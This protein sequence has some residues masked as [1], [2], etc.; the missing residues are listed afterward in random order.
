MSTPSPSSAQGAAGAAGAA[1]ATGAEPVK[2]DWAQPVL[3][4]AVT[5][6]VG[7][8]GSFAVVLTGLRAVGADSAQA[9]SG[10][11]VL[12]LTM[13]GLTV[14]L[15]LRYR[16][17][18]SIV[19]STPGAAVLASAGLVAGGYGTAI[20]AFLV[21]GLLIVVTGAIPRV[22]GLIKAIPAQL[23]AALLAGVLFPL[24]SEPVRAVAQLP[25]QAGTIV[26]CWAVAARFFPRWAVPVA[27]AAAAVVIAADPSAQNG[28]TP[29]SHIGSLIPGLTF[30]AP[31]FSLGALVGLALPLFIVTM[32]SQNVP[33]IAVLDAYGYEPPVRRIMVLTGGVTMLAAPFGAVALNLSALTAAMAAGPVAHRD[34]GRRWIAAVASACGYVVLGLGAGL[35]VALTAVAS[36]LLVETVAGLAL[37]N[38]LT[39]AL[40]T[41][42]REERFR[43]P[44]VVTFLVA[45]SGLSFAGV[46]SPFWG[47][48]AGLAFLGLRYRRQ[49][50]PVVAGAVVGV[51]GGA[52]VSGTA[53][54]GADANAQIVAPASGPPPVL[55][56]ESA[57]SGTE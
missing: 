49:A 19:W 43:E 12:S 4:G 24:C 38:A 34:P 46:S 52:A 37:I 45:A 1:D 9:V 20:G 44:A 54:S 47:L 39:G 36:P 35:A 41:A 6:I 16:Q 21:V 56:A 25:W 11:M 51:V 7:F 29:G 5:A 2:R 32:A 26:V 31:A 15:S 55:A 13:A 3:A 40:T 18:I 27:L 17:P 57:V 33:G 42:V 22:I 28:R 10:L 30:T 48:V 53:V 8:V 14:F 50:A 23:A